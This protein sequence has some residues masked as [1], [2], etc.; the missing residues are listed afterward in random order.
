L[1]LFSDFISSLLVPTSK[2]DWSYTS[3]PTTRLH[4]VV[5]S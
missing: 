4:G 1:Y 2:N 3:T 5:L